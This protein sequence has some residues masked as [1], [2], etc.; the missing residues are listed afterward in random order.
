MHTLK[1]IFYLINYP[2]SIDGIRA[3]LSDSMD[4]KKSLQQL[5]SCNYSD[6][7]KKR[8]EYVSWVLKIQDL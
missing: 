1:L 2:T 5:H 7:V 4:L 8:L 6:E 3:L